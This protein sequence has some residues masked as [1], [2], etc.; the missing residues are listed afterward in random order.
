MACSPHGAPAHTTMDRDRL[1]ASL[2]TFPEALDAV[3]RGVDDESARIRPREGAWSI[4]EVARHLLD[5]ERRD[6]RP[7]IEATLAGVDWTPIDPEGWARDEGY[8]EA[9]LAETAE[10]FAAERAASIAWLEGLE[11]PDWSSTYE[12]P[13][14]GTLSAGDLLVSWAAHDDLHLGQIARARALVLAD[15]AAPWSVHYAT[16]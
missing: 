15:W 4:V 11:G 7:R 16:G 10:A 5:E 1:T 14:L 8:R 9:S 12:H 6:F 2:R 3:I 13:Q